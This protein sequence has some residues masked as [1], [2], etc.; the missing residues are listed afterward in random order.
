MSVLRA[1]ERARETLIDLDIVVDDRRA[2][3]ERAMAQH[4]AAVAARDAEARRL[5]ALMSQAKP[6]VLLV[7]VRRERCTP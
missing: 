2:D 7:H 6:A 4:D 1:I 5:R 3:V